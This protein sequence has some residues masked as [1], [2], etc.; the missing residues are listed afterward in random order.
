MNPKT[1]E[2]NGVKHEA[3]V[4]HMI[5]GNFRAECSCGWHIDFEDEYDAAHSAH[6]HLRLKYR[7]PKEKTRSELLMEQY[8]E[9]MKHAH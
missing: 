5:N 2:I 3:E 7:R 8:K 1:K 6:H 4:T 9:E